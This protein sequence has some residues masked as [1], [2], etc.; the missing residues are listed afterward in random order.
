MKKLIIT[1]LLATSI[2]GCV[3]YSKTETYYVICDVV[4]TAETE[5]GETHIT[6]KMP[7][8]ELH[9]YRITDAPEEIELVVFRTNNQDDYSSYKVVTVR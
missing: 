8:G 5:F 9:V 6:C 3:G 2:L 4:E 1:L 7:N